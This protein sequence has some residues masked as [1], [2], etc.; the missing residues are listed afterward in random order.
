MAAPRNESHPVVLVTGAGGF[1]GRHVVRSLAAAGWRVA[2]LDLPGTKPEPAAAHWAEADLAEPSRLGPLLN[3]LGPQVVVHAGGISGPMVLPDDPRR[4]HDINVGGTVALLEAMRASGVQRLAFCSSMD[5]Y[6]PLTPAHAGE[7]A[8]L[9]PKTVYAASKAAAELLI[10]GWCAQFGLT[11]AALRLGWIYGPGRTTQCRITETLVALTGNDRPSRAPSRARP[12]ETAREEDVIAPYLYVTDAAEA[13]KHAVAARAPV[14]A[15]VDVAGPDAIAPGR[16]PSLIQRVMRG[17]SLD[18][19]G[20]CE[21]PP[22][23]ALVRR[24]H[25]RPMTGLPE[26][27]ETLRAHLVPGDT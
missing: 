3:E 17:E 22:M 1:L 11:A 9:A 25:Y 16:V 21:G 2:G 19:C 27:I 7:T 24:F 26:G 4:V 8:P 10:Q 20:I 18:D 12:A 23:S 6:G 15:A 14:F 13:V 5:V